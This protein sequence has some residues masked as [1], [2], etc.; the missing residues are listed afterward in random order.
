M[1]IL[2]IF[3]SKKGNST[4][5]RNVKFS[6]GELENTEVEF[7]YGKLYQNSESSIKISSNKN[8]VELLS[9]LLDN[10]NPPFY[11]LYVLVVSRTNKKQRRYQSPL[12]KS[13][14]EII[15]FLENY[16]VYI[17][18]DGRHHIWICTTDN[19]GLLV[20]DQHNVIFGY[21]A[22]KQFQN[23]ITKIGYKEKKFEF[24]IPHCH[25]FHAENDK[26]EEAIINH[27]EW[28]L[29][30]LESNDTYDE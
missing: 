15:E 22:I 26:Y 6:K 5:N 25:S 14:A 28:E 9:K 7:D 27:F 2:N 23:T 19:S 13:K 12:F 29:F 11:I 4:G 10:L 24:P 17:E 30:P 16:K 3:K 8:Q 1:K 21:G 18:T 20:Y